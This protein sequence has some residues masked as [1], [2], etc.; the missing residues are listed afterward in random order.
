MILSS[1]ILDNN[2]PQN[3]F[4]LENNNYT[5]IKINNNIVDPKLNYEGTTNDLITL[6][7]EKVFSSLTLKNVWD[8]IFIGSSRF[9]ISTRL[10]FQIDPYRSIMN[11]EGLTTQ[12]DYNPTSEIPSNLILPLA[13]LSLNLNFQGINK[14][15]KTEE[16]QFNGYIDDSALNKGQVNELWESNVI[17][18]N[19]ESL[20][21]L[22]NIVKQQHSFWLALKNQALV[23][24]GLK[25]L[26]VYDTLGN[27]LAIRAYGTEYNYFILKC[28]VK[29]K[30]ETGTV[31]LINFDLYKDFKQKYVKSDIFLGVQILWVSNGDKSFVKL[32]YDR[33]S[34]LTE[35]KIQQARLI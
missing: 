25:T 16:L 20:P 27:T 5:D 26:S 14:S 7:L 3:K 10:R 18:Q 35:A 29:L 32:L 12:I 17:I 1:I 30:D 28:I 11:K 22:Y 8:T 9:K 21:D 13:V 15:V 6:S 33:T 4:Y 23:D 31:H 34:D 2:S 24:K 19:K